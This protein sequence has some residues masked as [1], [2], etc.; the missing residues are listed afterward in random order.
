MYAGDTSK[1]YETGRLTH[2]LATL[3]SSDQLSHFHI[4][5]SPSSSSTESLFSDLLHQ[6]GLDAHP[7]G[8]EL[9]AVVPTDKKISIAQSISY[10]DFKASDYDSYDLVILTIPTTPSASASA[11]NI[12]GTYTMPHNSHSYLH[13]RSDTTEKP[14]E[15]SNTK[16]SPTLRAAA[17]SAS[18]LAGIFPTCFPSKES[19]QSLTRNCTSHGS[20]SLK[21]T[22]PSADDK[23]P[24]KN[25]YTCECKPEKRDNGDGKT[26]TTYWGGPACQK[27]DVSVEFWMIVLFSVA[28]VGLVGFAVGSVW[29]MG[30]EELPSVIGA[31]VSGPV[32]RR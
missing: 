8:F 27:K 32:A 4:S 30:E 3:P 21:Y 1:L 6:L 19:C 20:C 28:M 18:P 16:A 17:S 23:S 24:T 22:D 9:P 7:A 5:P 2:Y 29:G 13:K 10:K 26:K 14:L 25:C 12:W 15:L 11:E 31:G